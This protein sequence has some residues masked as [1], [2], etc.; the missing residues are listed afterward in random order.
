MSD[1]TTTHPFD[2]LLEISKRSQLRTDEAASDIVQPSAMMGKLALR[3][4]TLHLMVSMDDI[5]EIIPLPPLTYVPGVKP[6]LIGIAN[7]RG[8][9]ISVVNLSAFLVNKASVPNTHSRVIVISLGEWSYGLLVD[10]IIGMRH[11]PAANKITLNNAINEELKTYVKEA[12]SGEEKTWLV[13]NV[14]A[15]L[16]SPHFLDA[17][18]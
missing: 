8:T 9:V 11:F 14:D 18:A 5:E 1:P 16:H 7:L 12:Y 17:A 4:D 3:V 10:E 13:F 2:L 6:W 15:L